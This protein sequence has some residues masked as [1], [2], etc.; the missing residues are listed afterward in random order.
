[1]TLRTLDFAGDLAD[2]KVFLR[3]D[4]DVPL[5]PDG[6]I[7]EEYRI[8]RQRETVQHL[9]SRGARV[10]MGGHSSAA[11]SLEPLVPQLQRILGAQVQ[12]CSD[13]DAVASLKGSL[14]LLEN[15][16]SNPGEEDNNEAFA[17]SLVSGCDL[18]VS[19]AFAVCHRE[20]ASVATAPLMVPSYAG[21]L[22]AEEVARLGELMDAPAAGKV[23]FIGGAKVS[24][25]MPVIT[26]LL[27]KA[28]TIAVGGKLA[29]EMGASTDARVCVPEDF[30]ES[31]GVVL[32]I[33]PKSAAAFAQ[34]ARSAKR[35]V[36][37]GPMGKFEDDRF[38]AG[39]RVLAEALAENGK[40]VVVGGGDTVAALG[41][42]GIP[43]ETFGFVSTGGGAMLAFL[44]GEQLPGLKVLGL[45][46]NQR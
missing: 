22:V 4:V 37:N 20:H 2:K 17:G 31:D 42:F 45:Y 16:R 41:K 13:F 33:G 25:K 6:V 1:M 36:W 3:I 8:V 44:A 30:I 35:V 11:P 12:F 26:N 27:D 23:V 15:L 46:D 10:V 32:D 19:N 39:T 40:A 9:L 43:L 21:L 14:A 24:T 38:E 29:N 5:G 18:M 34:L 7:G 28:E